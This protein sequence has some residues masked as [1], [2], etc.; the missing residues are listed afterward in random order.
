VATPFSEHA[1]VV[2][3]GSGPIGA[4]YAR[5]IV[6][7]AP[8][9]KVLL[10]EAGPVIADP[11]GV[12]IGNIADPAQ[13]E[14]AQ[15][16]SQGPFQ[17][18]YP[19]PAENGHAGNVSDRR[20]EA[21]TR[22]PGLYAVGSG[23]IHGDGFPAAQAACNVG[24]MGSHW[25]NACPR[26]S[27]IERIGFID[28]AVLDAAYDEAERLLGVSSTQFSDSL[29]AARVQHTVGELVNVGR[30]A[31]RW[32]QHMPLSVSRTA[33][34]GLRRTGPD[35]VLGPLLDASPDVFELRT[36]TVCLRVVMDDGVA[37]GVELRDRRT[38]QI[39]RVSAEHVVVAADSLRTPQVLFASGVRP[40]ALGHHL[41]EHPQ[42]SVMAEV[43]DSA[44]R[45]PVD[46][47]VGDVATMADTAAVSVISSGVTWIPYGGPES[48][49]HGMLVQVDPQSLPEPPD[50]RERP[51]SAMSVHF[52]L[53]QEIQFDNA[54]SFSD[55]EQDWLGMPAMTIHHTLSEAD[56]EALERGKKALLEICAAVGRPLG[57]EEPWILPSGSSL[58]YQGTVRMGPV[59][60]GSSV[61][62][63][64]SRVWGTQN[65]YVAGN[66]VIPTVTACNPTLTST[67]LAILGAREIARR[68]SRVQP[69]SA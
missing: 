67:A 37:T 8:F 7:A 40:P 3:I 9:A 26:P 62:D 56:L 31:D 33:D 55:T 18:P 54:V 49:F 69:A 61:C 43:D 30:T 27:E 24:G 2:I 63:P 65:L 5:T 28:R 32:V 58:H 42:V 15:V 16:A 59:D 50:G 66:G 52:F 35:V 57:D 10:V 21:L 38:G 68:L 53:P 45:G 12:H 39:A 17:H 13:R 22:R 51:R 64:S 20:D 23:D 44:L 19:R 6:E 14:A 29:F 48:P 60:D 36:E 11:P 46:R 41:N 34:G 47:E 25:F 4:T 1:D